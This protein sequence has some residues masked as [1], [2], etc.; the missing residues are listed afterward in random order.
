MALAYC[1]LDCTTCSVYQATVTGDR[2]LQAQCAREWQGTASEHWGLAELQPEQMSCRG[3]KGEEPPLFL[4]C[5]RCPIRSCARG[6]GFATC[7]ECTDWSSCGRLSG[8]LAD[9]PAAREN[10]QQLSGAK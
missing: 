4:S 9:V 7:A 1:G 5:Q 8:L 2:E 3:C 6:R 10:L